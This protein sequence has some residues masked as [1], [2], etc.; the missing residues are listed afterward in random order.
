M[1]SHPRIEETATM[2]N[3]HGRDG[4]SVVIRTLMLLGAGV[5]GLGS[6]AC[7]F[8]EDTLEVDAPTQVPASLLDDPQHAQL[9]ISGVIGDFDCALGSY[10][11]SQ[12]LIGDEL[13]DGTFT[14]SRW[15]VPSRNLSGTETYGT[16]DCTGNGVYTPLSVARWS[17]D[18]AV[19]KLEGWTD[20]QVADRLKKIGIAA[21]YSGYAHTLMGEGMCTVAYDLSAELQPA[22]AFARAEQRFTRAIEAATGAGDAE[23]LN[24]ARVGRARARLNLGQGAQAA[25]DAALVPADFLKV[26]V[27][28]DNDARSRNRIAAESPWSNGS[29]TA[30]AG[31]S[32]KE[33]YRG[34]AV[35]GAPDP[36][37][38]VT[39]MNGKTGD[40]ITDNWRQ[41]KYRSP[42]APIPIA[43]YDEAR[44][45]IAEVE[46]GQQAVGIINEL[47]AEYELAPF[48]STNEAEIQA[49]VQ[50]ERRREFFLEGHRLGD[51]RRND[52]PLFPAQA[53]PYNKG[54]NYGAARCFPLPAVEVLNN[55]NIN[56]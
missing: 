4:W 22:D 10:I 43:R 6:S 12:G 7:S 3:H 48:S 15:P 33:P 38:S 36:R 41:D 2:R 42:S 18:D 54:G 35:A 37:V 11:V 29:G 30:G 51:M 34:L 14:A 32:V 20:E 13:H 24:M 39:N 16:N 26:A 9:L 52:L 55:P 31:T 8:I 50:E 56:R 44:L 28:T 1:H 19:R 21:A 46:G 45:I 25:A 27:R 49:Q 17:A 5:L 47:R 40:A 23:T 53:E